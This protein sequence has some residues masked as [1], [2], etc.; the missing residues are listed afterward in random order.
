[1][2]LSQAKQ[3]RYGFLLVSAETVSDRSGVMFVDMTGGGSTKR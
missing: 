3:A 2:A 1:M